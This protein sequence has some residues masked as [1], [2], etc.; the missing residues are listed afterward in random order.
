MRGRWVCADSPDPLHGG[1]G[2][3]HGADARDEEP[4]PICLSYTHDPD[5]GEYRAYPVGK[6]AK[7]ESRRMHL[8]RFSAQ[9][10]AGKAAKPESRKMHLARYSAADA[11]ARAAAS[12]GVYRLTCMSR[13]P[14]LG[15]LPGGYVLNSPKSGSCV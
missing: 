15:P 12:A 14:G 9:E 13:A 8:A 6:A 2:N 3:L 1:R 4:D 11:A 7:P 5:Y 10:A